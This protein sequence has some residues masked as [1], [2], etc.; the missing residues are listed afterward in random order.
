[1]SGCQASR[2]AGSAPHRAT[3]SL[4][5]GASGKGLAA[6]ADRVAHHGPDMHDRAAA[7]RAAGFG[8][9]GRVLAPAAV[10]DELLATA[11]G[12]LGSDGATG[13]PG[14]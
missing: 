2:A 9:H 14:R 7:H 6:P 1:M 10:R 11:R 3:G 13:Q 8:A 5:A 4:I 12:I